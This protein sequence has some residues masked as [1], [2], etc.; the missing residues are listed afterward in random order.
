MPMMQRTQDVESTPRCPNPREHPNGCKPGTRNIAARTTARCAGLA[1]AL[2]VASACGS[3]GKATAPAT[4][5]SPTTTT[6]TATATTATTTS[7]M[8]TT[9]PTATT[10]GSPGGGAPS[11]AAAA[12]AQIKQNWE[13]FFDPATPLSGKAALL[14]NGDKL[15]PLLESFSAD[16]RVNQVK[17]QV[18]K[19]EFQ[20]PTSATVTYTLSLNGTVVEPNATG[21]AVLQDGTWKVSDAS[22]CGLVALAGTSAPGCG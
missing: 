11:D 8:T 4:S 13:K 20:S 2:L 14:E 9:S 7:P 21:K 10:T 5:S 3:S 6:T 12:E 17:A 22:L 18:T 19:V 16:P 15:M 1:L